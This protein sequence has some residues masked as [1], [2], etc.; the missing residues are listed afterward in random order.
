MQG[1][2]NFLLLSFPKTRDSSK[3][4]HLAYGQPVRAQRLIVNFGNRPRE[5]SQ[6]H[7]Y[8]LRSNIFGIY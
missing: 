4:I 1:V 5:Q 6:P 2:A 3:D 8:T 7:R